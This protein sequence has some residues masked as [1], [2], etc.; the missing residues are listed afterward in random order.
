[1][2]RRRPTKSGAGWSVCTS[3]RLIATLSIAVSFSVLDV[4]NSSCM[5]WCG[6]LP[7]CSTTDPYT[8][9]L[10]MKL[11]FSEKGHCTYL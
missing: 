9:W 7:V 11:V 6:L 3:D 1:M 10:E 4:R 8:V 2:S 5:H